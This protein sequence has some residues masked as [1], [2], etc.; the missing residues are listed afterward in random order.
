[1]KMSFDCQVIAPFQKI[2]WRLAMS[3]IFI[4]N[5]EIAVVRMR[6]TNLANNSPEQ[7]QIKSNLLNNKGLDASYKLLKHSI[8]IKPTSITCIHC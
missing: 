5:G 6:N 8:R 4:K 2:G 7:F 3:E 1:M